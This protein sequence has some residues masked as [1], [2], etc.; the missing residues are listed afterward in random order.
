M[1]VAAGGAGKTAI[2]VYTM[3]FWIAL[4]A[5]PVL[6]ERISR[7]GAI[8]LTFAGIGLLLV[9]M[10]LDASGLFAKALAVGGAI[11]WAGSAVYGKVLRA[12]HPAIDLVSLVT[13]QMAYGALPLVVVAALAPIRHVQPTPSFLLSIAYVALPGTALAWLLWMFLLSRLNAGVAGIAS[14]LT[15]IVG[16]L[17]AWLQLGER[18]GTLEIIGLC[19]IVAALIVNLLPA[20]TRL[21]ARPAAAK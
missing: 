4:F 14:L 6:H 5:W 13:W 11:L 15:P 20:Q 8:A 17:A 1:A 18:P 12:R 2:L 3:P 10:P 7:N 9:L 19:W 21:A 16:V